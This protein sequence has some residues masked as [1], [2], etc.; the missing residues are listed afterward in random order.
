MILSN[1]HVDN[2]DDKDNHGV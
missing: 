1:E 2:I